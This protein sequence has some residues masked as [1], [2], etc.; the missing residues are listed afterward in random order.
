M[1]GPL[2]LS[3][4][5]AEPATVSPSS[6]SLLQPPESTAAERGGSPVGAGELFSL[7]VHFLLI[8]SDQGEIDMGLCY[9]AFFPN[10]RNI[11]ASTF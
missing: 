5:S 2:S 4:A 1:R 6:P 7:R 11:Q 3:L 9:F 8:Y 10:K